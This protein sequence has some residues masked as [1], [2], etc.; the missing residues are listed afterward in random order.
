MRP[1]LVHKQVDCQGK[2]IGDGFTLCSLLPDFEG[3]RDRRCEHFLRLTAS[4]RGQV[5]GNVS[6]NL[7]GLLHDPVNQVLDRGLV[8]HPLRAFA[9]RH[10]R[11]FPVAGAYGLVAKKNKLNSHDEL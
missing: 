1:I 7:D 3:V 2:V 6:Y 8:F 4:G 10:Q 9:P 11:L 5:L